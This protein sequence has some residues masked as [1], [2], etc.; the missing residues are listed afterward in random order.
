M[1]AIYHIWRLGLINDLRSLI[2]HPNK[3]KKGWLSHLILPLF[4]SMSLTVSLFQ[5]E[6]LF[7]FTF[8]MLSF[9]MLMTAFSIMIELGTRIMRPEDIEIWMVRPVSGRHLYLAKYLQILTYVWILTGITIIIPCI[10]SLLRP[11]TNTLFPLVL[12]GTALLANGFMTAILVVFYTGLTHLLSTRKSKNIVGF[13]QLFVALLLIG[14]HQWSHYIPQ[15]TS[16]SEALDQQ[17]VLYGLPPLW[18]VIVIDWISGQWHGSSIVP[19]L[20][21]LCTITLWFM[22]LA[23]IPVHY[24]KLTAS[25]KDTTKSGEKPDRFILKRLDQFNISMETRGGFYLGWNLLK[26]DKSIFMPILA[27][28][29]L[30]LML[31]VFRLTEGRSI[32]LY[33]EP[34]Q[35]LWNATFPML[36]LAIFFTMYFIHNGLKYAKNHEACWCYQTSAFSRWDQFYR[37]IKIAIFI[38]VLL[39]LFLL[40]GILFAFT[41]EWPINLLQTTLIFFMGLIGFS[42]FSMIFTHLPFSQKRV[43]RSGHSWPLFILSSIPLVLFGFTFY[44]ILVIKPELTGFLLFLPILLL[45]LFE[46]VGGR[47]I[48]HQLLRQMESGHV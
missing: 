2:R 12:F 40:L 36:M 1:N 45:I 14:I 5:T 21:I 15:W 10:L 3:K 23:R 33:P 27:T 31:L 17:P 8:F 26:K 44:Y 47:K 43:Q 42:W 39:P 18:F 25:E 13:L 32:G 38:R 9:S 6:H 20:I 29:A 16:L 4:L 41:V 22:V 48:H 11:E 34:G 37:G 24:A 35:S 7:H 46:T 19:V 28:M 30:P